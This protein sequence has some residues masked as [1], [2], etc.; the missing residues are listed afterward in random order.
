MSKV[1]EEKLQHRVLAVEV[2]IN[3]GLGDARGLSDVFDLGA[4]QT[5]LRDQLRRPVELTGQLR[6]KLPHPTRLRSLA[7]Q[8]GRSRLSTYATS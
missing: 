1:A 4:V 7:A 2:V 3:R 5:A 6:W 8:L